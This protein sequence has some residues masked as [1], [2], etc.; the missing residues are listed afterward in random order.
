[1]NQ[2]YKEIKIIIVD[3]HS[4]DETSQVVEL[5]RNEDDRIKYVRKCICRQ[6]CFLFKG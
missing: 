1:M 6:I 2:N 5:L 4:K 3:D